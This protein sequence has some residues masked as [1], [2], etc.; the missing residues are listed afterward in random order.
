MSEDKNVTSNVQTRD[1][2]WFLENYTE[3]FNKYGSSFLAIKNETVIGKYKTYAE[4]VRM[5]SEDNDLGTF[6]VQECN[7]DESA[8][9][10]YISS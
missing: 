3:L 4:G 1:F 5:A 8:Y 7:G 2:Q 9:T 6:I 10:I